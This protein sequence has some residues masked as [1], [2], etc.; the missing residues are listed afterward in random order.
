M[1]CRGTV[2]FVKCPI[3][4]VTPREKEFAPAH[5]L[6]ASLIDNKRLKKFG[7]RRRKERKKERKR[8]R[9]NEQTSK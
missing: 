4:L 7:C 9:E 5:I 3:D 1:Y 8:E 6:F 2:S